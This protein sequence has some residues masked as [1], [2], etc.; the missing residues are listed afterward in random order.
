MHLCMFEVFFE[1][2]VID[3]PANACIPNGAPLPVSRPIFLV[4]DSSL[5]KPSS[6]SSILDI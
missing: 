2:Q 1:F 3:P 4:V 6:S 5:I